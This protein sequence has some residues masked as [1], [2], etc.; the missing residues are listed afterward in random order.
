MRS[1]ELFNKE[2]FPEVTRDNPLKLLYADSEKAF[3]KDVTGNVWTMKIEDL[4]WEPIGIIDAHPMAM[5]FRTPFEIDKSVF[6]SIETAAIH[7]QVL[8]FRY[9][10][11]SCLSDVE[12]FKTTDNADK[13]QTV[14]FLTEL[15]N[16][17]HDLAVLG[18]QYENE[19]DISK[20]EIIMETIK[21]ELAKLDD[22]NKLPDE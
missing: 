4:T 7:V 8:Y 14:A 3:F 17:Y 13:E 6:P 18:D 12:Y 22:F 19:E 2:N 21:S 1:L 11:Q 15:A 10:E 20:K 16:R 5:Q 9:Q